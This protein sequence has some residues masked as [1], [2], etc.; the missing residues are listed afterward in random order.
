MTKGW[1]LLAVWALGL[2]AHSLAADAPTKGATVVVVTGLPGDVESEQ[3]YEA[4]VN[5][6]LQALVPAAARPQRL[7][8]LVDAPDRVRWPGGLTGEARP[9]TRQAFVAAAGEI[10]RSPGPLVVF[11]WGHGG[12]QGTKPVFH[13]RGPRLD[14]ADLASFAEAAG[15]RP[16]SWALFFRGSGSFAEAVVGP[17]RQVLASE[18]RVA[19]R[20]DPV[21]M[22]LLIEALRGMPE[23]FDL[24][25]RR[26]GAETGRWYE[27][28]GLVRTEEPTLWSEGLPR[29][30]A[31]DEGRED[32]KREVGPGAAERGTAPGSD[33][34][35]IARAAADRYPGADAVV[36]R[37]A[38]RLTL[39]E[40][41]AL[42][43]EVDEFVQILTPEG[44][45]RGDVGLLAPAG[46]RLTVLDC[47]IWKADGTFLRH[48][49]PAPPDPSSPSSPEG[50]AP[51]RHDFSLPGLEPG[52][53]LRV[54]TRR[55]WRRF[56]LPS[57]FVEVPLAADIPVAEGVVEVRVGTQTELHHGV[58]GGPLVEPEVSNTSYGKVFRWRVRD[59]PPV[60]SEALG[61]SGRGARLLLSTF[62]D[63]SSFSAWYERLI[64]AADEVTPEIQA[65]A[66]ALTAGKST[67]REKVAALY[68]YV[69]GLRYVAV[70]LGVN[71]HRPHA[72]AGVLKNRYGDCKDKANLFNTLLKSLGIPAHLVL[73]PRFSQADDAVPGLGFNHAISRV[74][75]DG[76]WVWADT[77]DEFARFGLLPPGDS[78]R[79]VLVMDGS[80][81]LVTLPAPRPE[82]HRLS[83]TTVVAAD[84]GL[85]TVTASSTGFVDY[86]LRQ[87]ARESAGSGATRPVLGERWAPLH[88]WFGQETATHTPVS[89]LE[90]AF[91]WKANGL[92]TG[93][94][95]AAGDGEVVLRAPFWLPREWETV[96][97][98]RRTGLF[99]NDGYPM[100][101]DQRVT[102]QIPAGARALELP[103][104]VSAET[105]PLSYRVEWTRGDGVVEARLRLTLA[106]AELD[107]ADARRFQEQL[108]GLARALGEGVRVKLRGER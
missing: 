89:S 18:H 54:H 63:W 3:A 41:P 100:V 44:E 20:S 62:A 71:S 68:D 6:L 75:L 19:F 99:L 103:R 12:V 61:P 85:A 21:G 102:R 25:A 40:T 58:L 24:L 45:S 22:E 80:A 76:D 39:A 105:P 56:P 50:G 15:R 104:G 65:A 5:R 98:A 26:V 82:D 28:H 97:H 9:A 14:A 55:E 13:V 33:W 95:L 66:A 36:L 93:L 83:V 60:V 69:A 42:V 67:E 48:E 23:S 35:G 30:L 92:W 77:T 88:G 101:L 2:P 74:R 94:D 64:R 84:T 52:A 78:G 90:S 107:E 32:P 11:M 38:E 59:V 4:Q 96:L 8:V 27:A 57:V 46:E 17:A 81:A 53:I 31:S 37:R 51:R 79:K 7:F 29:R 72:A 91:E 16:S 43:Q 106:A 70:P 73:V 10:A 34:E 86:A 47:E 1:R 49:P 87:A 108:R